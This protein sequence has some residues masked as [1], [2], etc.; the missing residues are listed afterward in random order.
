[1]AFDPGERTIILQRHRAGPVSN[2][3]VLE[4]LAT[5]TPGFIIWLE[6]Q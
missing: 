3:R 1:V 4:K 6:R 2:S 5:P